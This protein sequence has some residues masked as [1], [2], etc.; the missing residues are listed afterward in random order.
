MHPFFVAVRIRQPR[1]QASIRN[2]PTSCAG[3]RRHWDCYIQSVPQAV[4]INAAELDA[5]MTSDG[6][7]LHVAETLGSTSL[8]WHPANFGMV[9]YS[10]PPGCSVHNCAVPCR[11]EPSRAVPS[12]AEPCRAVVFTMPC[13]AEPCRAVPLGSQL[14]LF[15]HW[16]EPRPLPEHLWSLISQQPPSAQCGVRF[17]AHARRLQC[18]GAPVQRSNG[19]GGL[20]PHLRAPFMLASYANSSTSDRPP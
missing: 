6:T 13:R 1:P 4:L 3:L 14:C 7:Q 9:S 19:I 20:L 15:V 17:I 2:A 11:A 16:T 8:T 5:W 12:R 10:I 18:H